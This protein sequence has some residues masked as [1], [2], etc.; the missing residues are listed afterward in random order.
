METAWTEVSG[1]VMPRTLGPLRKQ[2]GL[3][4][5]SNGSRKRRRRKGWGCVDEYFTQVMGVEHDEGVFLKDG[6]D[7]PAHQAPRLEASAKEVEAF[8]D[9]Y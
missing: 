6:Q 2:R 5:S 7:D 9:H 4:S 1:T 8:K 3:A